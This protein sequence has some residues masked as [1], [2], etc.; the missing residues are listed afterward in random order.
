LRAACLEAETLLL[1]ELA[2]L[3]LSPPVLFR[4]PPRELEFPKM[5]AL[6]CPAP[7]AVKKLLH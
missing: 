5:L 6:P 4:G 2:T 3:L 7:P 1:C